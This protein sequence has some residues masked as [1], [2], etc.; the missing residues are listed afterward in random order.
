MVVFIYVGLGFFGV[1]LHDDTDI[2]IY[3][4]VQNFQHLVFIFL[5]FYSTD[6]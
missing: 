6:G 5:L 4:I 3:I 2:Y 1:D